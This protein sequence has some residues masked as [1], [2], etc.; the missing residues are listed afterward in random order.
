MSSLQEQIIERQREIFGTPANPQFGPATQT[1]YVE[2][3]GSLALG[4]AV[5][6]QV[7]RKSDINTVRIY[8]LQNWPK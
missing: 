6:V 2:W 7:M 4:E 1:A 5:V 8:P 3:A